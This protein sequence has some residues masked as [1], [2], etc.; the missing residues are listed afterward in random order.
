M[1][2]SAF[3]SIT[4]TMVNF[5]QNKENSNPKGAI[6]MDLVMLLFLRAPEPQF[7]TAKFL[8]IWKKMIIVFRHQGEHENFQVIINR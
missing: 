1:F 5:H 6:K 3:V 4:D 2:I 8:K 7:K